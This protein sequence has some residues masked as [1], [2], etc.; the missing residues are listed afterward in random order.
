MRLSIYSTIPD[1]K[2]LPSSSSSLHLLPYTSL[3]FYLLSSHISLLLVEVTFSF[4]RLFEME[5]TD[6]LAE[7]VAAVKR[8]P[9]LKILKLCGNRLGNDGLCALAD[10]F[11]SDASCG[12]HYLD[13][14]SNCIKPDGLLRFAKK[15]EAC[16][17]IKLRQLAISQN[18]L[19]RDPILAHEAL[20]S[21]EGVCCVHS[22]SWDSSQ[23][24]ADHVSVM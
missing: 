3:L 14:S 22:D 8:N 1:L 12:I 23:A 15:L 11:S 20:Q 21:L 2:V 9:S 18:L 10:L 7:F 16:G 24:F 4:C 19:D 5:S 6:F 13:V 17:K